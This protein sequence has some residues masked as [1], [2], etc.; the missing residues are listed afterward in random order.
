VTRRTRAACAVGLAVA[1]AAVTLSIDVHAQARPAD[2]I[3]GVYQAIAAD[4]VLTGGLRNTGGPNDIALRPGPAPKRLDLRDDPAVMCQSVGPFR[5]MARERVKL[6]IVPGPGIVMLLFEDLAHGR[7]RPIYL[8]RPHRDGVAPARLGDAV[9]RWDGTTLV[10]ETRGFDERA[11]LNDSGVQH[12]GALKLTERLRPV[13]GGRYLEYR[14]TADDPQTLAKPYSY[15]RY[16][17]KVQSE[18]E[19]DICLFE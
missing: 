3:T 15:T 17:E 19:E 18:I 14:V 9:G 2:G 13:L 4:T 12:S 11:L 8:N 6:E 5:M 16:L 1:A 7:V 10:I